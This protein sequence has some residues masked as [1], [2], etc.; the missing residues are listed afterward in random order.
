[1]NFLLLLAVCFCQNSTIPPPA[2]TSVIVTP[3]TVIPPPVVTSVQPPPVVT[4]VQVSEPSQSQSQVV[5][6]PSPSPSTTGSTA[7]STG[8]TGNTDTKDTG[9]N[10]GTTTAGTQKDEGKLSTGLTVMIVIIGVC[11]LAAGVGIYAFRVFGRSRDNSRS[12]CCDEREKKLKKSGI[13]LKFFFE[14][15]AQPLPKELV[16]F[17]I[18]P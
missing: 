10:T 2:A 12:G 17:K 4:S 16:R 18:V 14:G 5:S 7:G 15:G 3:T 8:N 13:F 6:Q 1:M 9:T 11:V